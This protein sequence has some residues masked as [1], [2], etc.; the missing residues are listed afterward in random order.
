MSD[1]VPCVLWRPHDPL[2]PTEEEAIRPHLELWRH[3]TEVPMNSLVI[4]RYSVLPFY[5]ELEE[6]LYNLGS[7]LINTYNQHLYVADLKNW[8]ADLQGL[9]P[10]TWDWAVD[11]PDIPLVVKGETNSRKDMWKTHMYAKNRGEAI[12]VML[13][14]MED[15]LISTQ[16]IYFREY[17][18]LHKLGECLSGKPITE[19]YR[20]F[21]LDG[22]ILSAG[23]YW[24]SHVADLKE[25]PDPRCVPETFLRE[26]LTRI[27][28]KVRFV[29]VDIAR[30]AD[31]GWTV[32][33]LNDGQMAGLSENDPKILYAN[34][35]K[36]L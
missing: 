36:Q 9:T 4:G 3:R 29:V 21:V 28:D 31:G 13:R 2:D 11:C 30:K 18:E 14:L 6:D 12:Q 17:V 16:K 20:F 32:I 26:V 5:K 24:S 1:L 15:S 19:E 8:Y 27:K 35:A 25:V 7:E 33:E 10:R 22:K 34:L 23:F